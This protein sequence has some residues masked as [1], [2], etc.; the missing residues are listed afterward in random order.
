VTGSKAWQTVRAVLRRGGRLA[1]Q[2]R[3]V[4]R[5]RT[6]ERDLVEAREAV[7]TRRWGA[8]RRIISTARKRHGLTY[9]LAHLFLRQLVDRRRLKLAGV[10]IEHHLPHSEAAD[11][12]QARIALR[13]GQYN[14]ARRALSK[15]LAGAAETEFTK[16]LS[17]QIA[18]AQ[19]IERQRESYSY[20]H[21]AIG[22]SSFCGSTVFSTVLGSLPGCFNVG[23][24]HHLVEKVD[25]RFHAGERH[26]AIGGGPFHWDVDDPAVLFPCNHC[27]PACTVFD[28]DFRRSL[29]GEGV[30]W[31]RMIAQKAGTRILVSSD[32]NSYFL[33]RRDPT[34]SFDLVVLFKSPADAWRSELKNKDR[35]RA[36]DVA[37]PALTRDMETY[38]RHWS[39]NYLTLLREVPTRGRIV[40]VDWESFTRSPDEHFRRLC[41]I[42]DLPI[43]EGIFARIR[44]D[45]HFFGGNPDVRSSEIDNAGRIDIHPSNANPLPEADAVLVAA[46]E[47]ARLVYRFLRSRYRHDFGDIRPTA[48]ADAWP[49]SAL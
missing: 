6:L 32:K 13:Q 28:A 36:A 29:N 22:G 27:G 26:A 23:E 46:N 5:E 35:L 30:D 48:T 33:L 4:L 20:R 39:Q 12:D 2:Y 14:V 41:D 19:A 40:A 43:V 9:D 17:K 25:L 49:A 45:Q 8:A 38:L 21:I 24:S 37:R 10:F 44:L 16:T 47:E 31:Y 1:R 11:V 42:L 3:S 15:A 34:A 18:T 7:H